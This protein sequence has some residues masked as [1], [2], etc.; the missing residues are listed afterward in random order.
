L[1]ADIVVHRYSSIS[2]FLAHYQALRKISGSARTE[3][4]R[5]RLDAIERLLDLLRPEE[6]AAIDSAAVDPFVVR[7]RE[8]ASLRL[9]REL[10]ARGAL[11]G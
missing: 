8:R 1:Q 7:H 3:D 4:E 2:A 6:R 11:D 10:M 5:H 9:R